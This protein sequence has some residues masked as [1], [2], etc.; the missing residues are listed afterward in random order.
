[1]FTDG[2][3]NIRLACLFYLLAGQTWTC[4]G[5]RVHIPAAGPLSSGIRIMAWHGL[6]ENPIDLGVS[7]VRSV[8]TITPASAGWVEVGW[9]PFNVVGGATAVAIGYEFITA[10]STYLFTG[11]ATIADPEPIQSLD[12]SPFFFA[13]QAYTG[14][15][16]RFKIGADPVG[17][18]PHWYGADVVLDDGESTGPEPLIAGM[19]VGGVWRQ[20][21]LYA[22]QNPNPITEALKT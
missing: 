6:H 10:A 1:V 7:P 22:G 9:P 15:R 17:P 3:P 20:G 12:G 2:T 16:S 4:V 21:I 18:A 19:M 13:E 14:G 5:G 8:E 11:S